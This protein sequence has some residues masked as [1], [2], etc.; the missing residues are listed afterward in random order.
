MN[1]NLTLEILK[2]LIAIDSQSHISN[3]QIVDLISLKLNQF[4]TKIMDYDKSGTKLYNL[5][6]KIKGQSDKN[7]LIFSGHTDTVRPGDLKNWKTNPFQAVEADG[8]VYGLGACDMKAGLACMISA[9]LQLKTVPK[10]DI[11]LI[12]D[13]DEEEG[14]TGGV[15]LIKNFEVRNA[16][17]IVAE[18]T[19]KEII[20]GHKG[21]IDIEIVIHGEEKHSAYT[22]YEYNEKNN[23]INKSVLVINALREHSKDIE[24][25]IDPALGKPNLTL[26]HISGGRGANTAAG[27]CSIKLSRRII[28]SE[29][30]ERVYS[31]IKDI[32][33][34]ACKDTSTEIIF[35]GAP[36]STEKED[37]FSKLLGSLSLKHLESERYG[38]AKGWTEAALFAKYG[39]VLIFGPGNVDACHRP[40][41]FVDIA[42]LDKFTKI[43]LELMNS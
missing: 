17:I 36:F 13:A 22:D 25:R 27:S 2:E 1:N 21:C 23:A 3:K 29:S 39:D 5:I 30:L 15:N 35:S 12:F 20:L 10:N 24:E 26:G 6:V 31:E 14:G 16:S 37:F 4:E 8:N 33:Q 42:D 28:R 11:Y 7:P 43:Y 34:K 38:F 32:V 41:E 19:T 9:A 40:N 18:P